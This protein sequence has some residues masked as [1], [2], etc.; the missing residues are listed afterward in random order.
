[1]LN[2]VSL[3]E[4][5]KVVWEHA[6]EF[7]VILG[8]FFEITPIKLSP[9]TWFL[10]LFY[11]PI[12]N[13]INTLKTDINDK[14]EKLKEELNDNIESVKTELKKE[15]D[16]VSSEQ[17]TQKENILELIRTNEMSEISRI[18]W[19]I[20]EFSNSIENGQLH[21]RD[22]YRHIIDDN[23]RYHTLIKKYG[24]ENGVIDEEFAKILKHY[25]DNKD[26]TSVYF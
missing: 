9:I 22:E 3:S 5:I 1:M 19:E 20:I 24:L 21:I 13:N 17:K 25:E 12:G 23:R 16:A 6:F 4:A 10:N 2:D 14:I 7:I 11:K 18:R 8:I 26:T 15:I